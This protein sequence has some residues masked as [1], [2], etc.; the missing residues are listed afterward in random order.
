[1]GQV[2]M[3]LTDRTKEQLT[4]L[5]NYYGLKSVSEV[6][7]KLALDAYSSISKETQN[8]STSALLITQMFAVKSIIDEFTMAFEND[9]VY[10]ADEFERLAHDGVVTPEMDRHAFIYGATRKPSVRPCIYHS[11]E[12]FMNVMRNTF[13]SNGSS[14]DW[15]HNSAMK[16]YAIEGS[17]EIV[18]QP[19]YQSVEKNKLGVSMPPE[20]GL[21]MLTA[22]GFCIKCYPNAKT[23]ETSP[24]D[25]VSEIVARWNSKSKK[26][27]IAVHGNV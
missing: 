25:F 9:W 14:A 26:F 11:D 12:P 15:E 7:T 6:V 1:M 5:K 4:V 16:I 18:I 3:S 8:C 17:P 24:S 2:N 10:S 20:S 22:S 21:M 27:D 19:L 23:A 13:E